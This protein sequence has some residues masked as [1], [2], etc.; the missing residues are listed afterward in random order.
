MGLDQGLL[1]DLKG[2]MGSAEVPLA[3]YMRPHQEGSVIRGKVWESP[4]LVSLRE[5]TVLRPSRDSGHRGLSV[6]H[7]EGFPGCGVVV[8]ERVVLTLSIK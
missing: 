6:P 1:C 8:L 4:V 3:V 7:G 5:L 2:I